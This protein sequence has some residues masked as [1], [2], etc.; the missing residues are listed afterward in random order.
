M[1][2]FRK[3]H[4]KAFTLIELL[5][6]IAIIAILAAILLPALAA[7]KERAKKISCANNLRQYGMAI[8]IY[9]ND[10]NNNLPDTFSSANP[11]PVNWLWD[12]PTNTVNLL[13]DN[14]SQ[15]HIMYDPAF[16]TQDN[17]NLWNFSLI[18][19]DPRWRVTGYVP[20][21]PDIAN[22]RSVGSHMIISNI[23]FSLTQRQIRIDFLGNTMGAPPA[24]E[25]VLVSCGI[26]SGGKDTVNLASDNFI[27]VVG[28]PLAPHHRAPHLTG[29]IP[30]GGNQ[31]MLDTHVEWHKFIANPVVST[32][33]SQN[34]PVYFWW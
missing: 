25:R 8:T 30:S 22:Y 13:T 3:P 34:I 7:A 24:T 14:G 33:R 26:I 21:Y 12:I 15:R 2:F 9:A 19:G 1:T 6:V 29:V 11:T 27:D 20:T 10:F 23:N 32:I 18:G 31:C 28:N 17:D 16:D 4:A 5:V